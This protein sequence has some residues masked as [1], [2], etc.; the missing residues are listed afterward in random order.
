[1]RVRQNLALAPTLALA[2]ALAAPGLAAAAPL[3]TP[4][5]SAPPGDVAQMIEAERAF[6]KKAAQTSIRDAFYEFLA[7]GAILFRPGPIDGKAYYFE[8]PSNPGPLLHWSPS[9]AEMAAS[10]EMGWTTGPW[11]YRSAAD[12]PEEA[13]GHFATVWHKQPR[14]DWKVIIDDG[15][16][17]TKPPLEP[18]TWARIGGKEIPVPELMPLATLGRGHERLLETD[19]AFSEALTKKGVGAALSEFADEDVRLYRE[20]QPAYQGAAIAGPALAHEWDRGVKAWDMKVGAISKA[21]DLAFTYGVVDLPPGTKT[22]PAG[23]NVFRV[24]RRVAE[25]PWKLALDVTNP[26]PIPP[27]PVVPKRVKPPKPGTSH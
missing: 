11:D 1:M 15:H 27:K 9:Y 7:P 8:K 12:K 5:A 26:F 17:S 20:E 6:N 4:R 21:G 14:G 2:L 19:G 10:G 25:G 16:S 3:V 18:L 24:W 22:D 13:W 23:R